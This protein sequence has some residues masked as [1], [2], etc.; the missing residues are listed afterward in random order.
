LHGWL[1]ENVPEGAGLGQITRILQNISRECYRA[2]Q[3][4]ISGHRR[5][6]LQKLI[7]EHITYHIRRT[8]QSISASC[9]EQNTSEEFYRA[10]QEHVANHIR[11]L[12]QNIS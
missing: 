1:N 2:Y 4:L 11:S 3:E 5:S 7:T 9:I 10:Y 8:L 6:L 12:L